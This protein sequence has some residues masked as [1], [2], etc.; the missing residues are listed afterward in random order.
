MGG[1]AAKPLLTDEHRITWVLGNWKQHHLRTAAAACAR[2][3][4]E[5]VPEA[6]AGRDPK[7]G[8]IRV[9]IAPP[10]L[11]LDAVA[12]FVRPRTPVW[13]LAQDIGAQEAGAFTG[14]VG[15][16][17]LAEAGVQAAIVGHSERRTHY[18]EDD[19]LVSR[20]VAAALAGGLTVVLCVGERLEARE[21]G[22]HE[23]TV[24]SQI[25][26]SL[27]QVKDEHVDARLVLAYEPVW[28]IGTGHTATPEQAS[29]MHRTIRAVLGERFGERGRGRSILYGGSVKPENAAD[30]MAAGD[31]DGFLVGG[32]SLDPSSFLAIVKAA[33]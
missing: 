19:A 31:I 17:M 11:S 3:I 18:R 8:E 25:S 10:Y 20:K 26:G 7:A 29:A 9:G 6:I 13:L 12:P 2:A 4:A 28:A 27:S 32:A 24:I 33:A 21:A 15:S 22:D 30:L 5:G 14:E 1:G 23:N 16:A